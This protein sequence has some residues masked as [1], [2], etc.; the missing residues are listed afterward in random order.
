VLDH[1]IDPD[2]PRPHKSEDAFEEPNDEYLLWVATHNYE[3][4][5][6]NEM[7]KRIFVS[8]RR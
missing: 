5:V 4:Q 3:C 6:F 1:L 2:E 8:C 7:D